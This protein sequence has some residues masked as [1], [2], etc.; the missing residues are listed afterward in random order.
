MVFL[1]PFSQTK[2]CETIVSTIITI[3]YWRVMFPI[4]A[5]RFSS[6]VPPWHPL[7]TCFWGHGGIHMLTLV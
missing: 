2:T 7:L 1:V 4:D 6:L 3:V 5:L